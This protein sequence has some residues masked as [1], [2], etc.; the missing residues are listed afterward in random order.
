[1]DQLLMVWVW[2]DII[3]DIIIISYASWYAYRKLSAWG[4]KFS[5]HIRQGLRS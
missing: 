3:A 5:Q 2:L 4:K 1:M